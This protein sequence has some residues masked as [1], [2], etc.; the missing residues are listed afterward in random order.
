MCSWVLHQDKKKEPQ[1]LQ[2]HWTCTF[3]L[4][5]SLQPVMS[6]QHPAGPVVLLLTVC[7]TNICSNCVM[8]K[9]CHYLFEMQCDRFGTSWISIID[10]HCWHF[11]LFLGADGAHGQHIHQR[12]NEHSLLH[13][14]QTI[15]RLNLNVHSK[16]HID[17]SV[18]LH[19]FFHLDNDLLLE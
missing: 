16:L 13:R 19:L 6:M 15:R 10:F 2:Q 17:Q 14:K 3:D 5:S 7:N 8:N 11:A 18:V 1:P 9:S 4:S 12:N